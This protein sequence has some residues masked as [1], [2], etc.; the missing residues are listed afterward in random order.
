MPPCN[1]FSSAWCGSDDKD[2][3]AKSSAA[4]QT[5]SRVTLIIIVLTKKEGEA[6]PSRLTPLYV[7]RADL[8]YL[9]ALRLIC[10]LDTQGALWAVSLKD[11][12]YRPNV[13]I[14]PGNCGGQC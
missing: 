11:F 10:A 8:G 3:E 7:Y 6:F 2:V 5:V 4:R 14:R 12:G 9:P 1:H 13:A